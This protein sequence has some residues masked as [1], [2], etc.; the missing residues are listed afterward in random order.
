MFCGDQ[1]LKGP[2]RN[3]SLV[4][5]GGGKSIQRSCL[6]SWVYMWWSGCASLWPSILITCPKFDN[7]FFELKLSIIVLMVLMLK[8]VLWKSWLVILL[9][10]VVLGVDLQ[11]P[12]AFLWNSA[13]H[14]ST[15]V[16]VESL[17]CLVR[18]WYATPVWALLWVYLWTLLFNND[19]A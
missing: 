4:L 14:V 12:V 17:I 11:H 3:F 8:A 15:M 10:T 2:L 19:R 1:R 5:L 18:V 16:L 6:L 7:L 9:Q 13:P